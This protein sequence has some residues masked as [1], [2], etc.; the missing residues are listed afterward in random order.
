M[1]VYQQFDVDIVPSNCNFIKSRLQRWCF[2]RILRNFSACNV[3]KKEAPTQVF[4]MKFCKIFKTII[5]QN[6]C[7][8]LSIITA[9]FIGKNH[10]SLKWKVKGFKDNYYLKC[11]YIF[12]IFTMSLKTTIILLPSRYQGVIDTNPEISCKSKTKFSRSERIEVFVIKI[13]H[14]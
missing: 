4:S 14:L 2:L 1:R 11:S 12:L 8:G 7:K 5:L 3:I 9:R 10:C 13:C 6:N